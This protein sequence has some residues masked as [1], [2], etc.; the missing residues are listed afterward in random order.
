M[1]LLDDVFRWCRDERANLEH[2]R[3]K[4]ERGETITAEMRSGQAHDTTPDTMARVRKQIEE[5][6]ALL[7][8]HARHES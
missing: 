4:L 2:Q 6:D 3:S 8:R 5:L 7:A 1:G